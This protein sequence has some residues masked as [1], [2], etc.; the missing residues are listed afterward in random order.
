MPIATPDGLRRGLET[1][2]RLPAANGAPGTIVTF[3]PEDHRGY[4]GADYLIIRRAR[5]GTT[6]FVA[7]APVA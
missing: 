2:R 6:E 5:G 7:T 1:I 4:K 3:G